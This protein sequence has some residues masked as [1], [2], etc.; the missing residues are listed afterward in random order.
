M[1]E[2]I[3]SCSS[4]VMVEVDNP[5]DAPAQMIELLK[6]SLTDVSMGIK[7]HVCMTDEARP[8]VHVVV[9]GKDW[10]TTP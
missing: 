10:V 7:F 1:R 5:E 9:G 2:A 8:N 6:L 3:V 4:S